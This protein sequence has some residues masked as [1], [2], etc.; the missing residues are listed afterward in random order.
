MHG[1]YVRELRLPRGAT[2]SLLVRDGEAFTPTPTPGCRS[3]DQLLV[4]TPERA[5]A[6]TER[7][8]R[9]VGRGGA[10]AGWFGERRRAVRTLTGRSRDDGGVTDQSDDAA[11]DRGS[12]RRP[13]REARRSGCWRRSPLSSWSLDVMT[14]VVV[15]ARLEA[16]EPVRAARRR[17]STWS[18]I[19]NP[20]AAF[21]LATGMTWVL[22]LVAIGGGRGDRP[23]GAAAAVHAAGRSRSGWCSAGR[24]ATSIDRIFRAPGLAAGPRRR[25]RVAVRAGRRVSSRCSTSP[26]RRSSSAAIAAGARSR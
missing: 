26:T 22:A 12:R 15:V 17:W 7:R 2:M 16:D 20:G 13:P 9:A 18:L 21:S 10:L 23:D 8:L 14:K 11:R 1:V 6:A 4:V 24:S 3:G 25:L 19:R 5:R